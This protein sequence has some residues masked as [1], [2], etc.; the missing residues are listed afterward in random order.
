MKGV[1][2]VTLTAGGIIKKVS[3]N[4]AAKVSFSE[5]DFDDEGDSD[6]E[7]FE[8][9]FEDFEDKI[10]LKTVPMPKKKP[11]RPKAQQL[12]FDDD[13]YKPPSATKAPKENK[14]IP[15]L[16]AGVSLSE[17]IADTSAIASTSA[18]AVTSPLK[19]TDSQTQ[20]EVSSSVM[21]DS[22]ASGSEEP[23]SKR[24][25]KEKKIFDL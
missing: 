22:M 6:D 1:S 11:G 10:P 20:F 14:K 12:P 23:R 3:S 13:E 16:K 19:A 21:D 24:A 9:E 25:R 15:I 7:M 8:D 5:N 2:M 4:D 17:D 18:G